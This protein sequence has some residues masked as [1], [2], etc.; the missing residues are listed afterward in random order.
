MS[1]YL[2]KVTKKY[3]DGK[4]K[5]IMPICQFDMKIDKGDA[6]VITGPSGSGK[7]TLLNIIGLID[8]VS[9]GHYF[10]ENENVELLS[11]AK[12]AKCRNSYFGYIMQDYGI[13][14][15]RNV[16]ENVSLPLLFNKSIKRNEYKD[17]I[18]WA[19]EQVNM[20]DC[21]K[22]NVNELSG[23]EKQRVA[24]ARAIVNNPKVIL[25]D[26]PTGA[27]DNDS[28]KIVMKTLFKLNEDGKTI[29]VVTHDN[30]IAKDFSVEYKFKR[31]GLIE[32]L[33]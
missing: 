15:Y 24:I 27:L 22:R 18:E 3:K 5:E 7:S 23:G 19:L 4:C 17:K 12:K 11:K 10:L 32:R 28:K 14:T 6:V 25:A 9:S 16:F 26:E 31:Q 1:I 29:I 20:L 21:Y 13:I 2:D 30:D 8:E 33:R